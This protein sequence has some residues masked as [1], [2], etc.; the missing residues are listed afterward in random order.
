MRLAVRQME[1]QIPCGDNINI[2]TL[3]AMAVR[4]EDIDI[5]SETLPR[6]SSDSHVVKG[7]SLGVHN[8]SQ[9]E[10]QRLGGKWEV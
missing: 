9:G 1:R 3:G 2:H 4:K 5:N 8:V 6:Y 10:V 7:R